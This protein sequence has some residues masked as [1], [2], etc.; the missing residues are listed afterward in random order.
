MLIFPAGKKKTTKQD[1]AR[2]G[3]E[4][5]TSEGLQTERNLGNSEK[6]F[7]ENKLESDKKLL[8]N[9]VVDFFFTK[10]SV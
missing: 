2:K 10:M 4:I 6:I 7:P 9:H 8:L 5:L 3:A 1:L